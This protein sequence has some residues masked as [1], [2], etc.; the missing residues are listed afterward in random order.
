METNTLRISSPLLNGWTLPILLLVPSF[1]TCSLLILGKKSSYGD[2]AD[3]DV[4]A[5]LICLGSGYEHWAIIAKDALDKLN[6]MLNIMEDNRTPDKIKKYFNPTW[7]E[8]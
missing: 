5:K 1:P 8:D 2:L 6:D 7:D 3:D 4:V